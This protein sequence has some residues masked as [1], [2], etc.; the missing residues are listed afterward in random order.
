MRWLCMVRVAGTS[1]CYKSH[2]F[3]EIVAYELLGEGRALRVDDHFR[4]A[5]GAAGQETRVM[6]WNE[7]G[8]KMHGERM[9]ILPQLDGVRAFVR[10][11]HDGKRV[12]LAKGIEFPQPHGANVELDR[13]DG[14]NTHELWMDGEL[15][16]G[17]TEWEGLD[18]REW[19]C[20]ERPTSACRK[21]WTG[22]RVRGVR[23]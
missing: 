10:Q 19:Q 1:A 4:A 16:V 6:E 8:K 14:C 7:K 5:A 21:R 18:V 13:C 3:E 2:R 9:R 22:E 23:E 17:G 20:D 15:V 12:A 11:V